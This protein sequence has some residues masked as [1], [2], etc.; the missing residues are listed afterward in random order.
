MIL[1]VGR[2]TT[3]C[4]DDRLDRRRP[5]PP[6]FEGAPSESNASKCHEFEKSLVELPLFIRLRKGFF[7]HLCH[8]DSSPFARNRCGGRFHPCASCSSRSLN[9]LI[10]VSR[11]PRSKIGRA[12]V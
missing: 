2:L 1:K 9:R 12:H 10:S 4:F 3:L 5:S 7:L 8:D 6:R 11:R